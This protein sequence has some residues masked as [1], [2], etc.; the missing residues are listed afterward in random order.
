[1]TL[2]IKYIPRMR[3]A[4]GCLHSVK[5]GQTQQPHG[6]GQDIPSTQEQVHSRPRE[7]FLLVLHLEGFPSRRYGVCEFEH[8]GD[9]TR[10]LVVLH[11]ILDELGV[12]CEEVNDLS[13]LGFGDELGLN[14]GKVLGQDDVGVLSLNRTQSDVRVLNVGASVSLKRRHSLNVKGVVVDSVVLFVSRK[15]WRNTVY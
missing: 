12:R 13:S 3:L 6:T 5:R 2:Q 9:D 4:S 11:G 10:W 8:V 15:F 14:L 1:M 7:F